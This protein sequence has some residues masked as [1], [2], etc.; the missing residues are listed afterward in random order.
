M[1]VFDQSIITEADFIDLSFYDD[2]LPPKPLVQSTLSSWLGVDPNMDTKSSVT[3]T[4]A[5]STITTSNNKKTKTNQSLKRSKSDIT[6]KQDPTDEKPELK[7]RKSTGTPVKKGKKVIKDEQD[8][9]VQKKP[10]KPRN[11]VI[12]E[13]PFYKLIPSTN[14][15]GIFKLHYL[16]F[17]LLQSMILEELIKFQKKQF[18]F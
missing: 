12:R 6:W 4:I 9:E 3:P 2:E 11:P 5:T 13:C 7:R 15:I 16:I 10:K 18:I 8:D 1:S 14:V 17:I